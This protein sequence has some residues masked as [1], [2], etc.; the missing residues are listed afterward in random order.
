MNVR[1]KVILAVVL[2]AASIAMYISVFLKV[3]HG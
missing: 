3:S 1:N 2:A